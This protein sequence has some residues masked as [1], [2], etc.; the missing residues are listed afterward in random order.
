MVLFHTSIRAPYAM[1]RHHYSD[2]LG[3]AA[4]AGVAVIGLVIL[5]MLLYLLVKA[6]N[7]IIRT[8][9]TYPKNK[10]LWISLIVFVVCALLAVITKENPVCIALAV[11]SF[12]GL[13]ATARI[14]ELY[15]ADLFQE[16]APVVEKVLRKPWWEGTQ[17]QLSA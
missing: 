3:S 12:L 11:C 5:L 13:V 4:G 9:A 8:I 10:P 2:D 7:L 15:Y 16:D 6:C 14:V 1:S 17:Q